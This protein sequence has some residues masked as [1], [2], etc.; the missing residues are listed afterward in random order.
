MGEGY[1]Y[2]YIYSNYL[3]FLREE[4]KGRDVAVWL[5]DVNGGV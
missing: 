5:A 2:I 3:F 4:H 1:I